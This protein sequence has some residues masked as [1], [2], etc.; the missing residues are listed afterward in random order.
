M[1]LLTGD[2]GCDPTTPL[3][4]P[5][6]RTH[7]AARRRRAGRWIRATSATAATFAD[8][9]ATVAELLGVPWDLE[10][11]SFAPGVGIR[12][13]SRR[14]VVAAKRDGRTL[15]PDELA[16]VRPGLRPRR[17]PRLPGRGACS[18]AAFFNGPG[19]VG[20]ARADRAMVDSGETLAA[21]T[22]RPAEGRQALDRRRGR[23][24]VTLAFA[25]IAA[26]LGLR[27]GQALRPRARAHGRDARQ[28]RVDPGLPHRPGSGRVR[29]AG[30]RRSVRGGG[31][32]RRPR[33]GRRR[34]VRAPRRHGDR[35]VGP[36]DRGERD[37]QE[38][39]GSAPT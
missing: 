26:A 7:A 18:M 19:R 34:A 30:A 13:T 15:H 20:D 10:G 1:L 9:G 23:Q 16:V 32:D 2:H 38:A 36:A 22:H 24:D 11:A 21:R 3:D 12:V 31:A 28:A 8:L 4:R 39:R 25:P 33:P 14:D 37:V 29:T 35:A 17:D 27:R 5:L 6:A